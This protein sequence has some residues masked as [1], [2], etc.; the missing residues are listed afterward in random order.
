MKRL[1]A[2]SWEMPPMYGPRATQVSRVLTALPALGWSPT[3]VC[4]DP[5][6]GGPHWFA[7]SAAQNPGVT[8]VRVPSRQESFVVRATWRI[9]PMLRDYPDTARVW[10]R[11]A[12]HAA[13]RVAASESPA[14]L[15]S[16][17]QPWSDHLI[18]LRV[19]RATQLPWVAHFSDPWAD[20]PYA[21]LRQ[22]SIWGRMEAEVIRDATAVVFV[23]QETADL[24]M[25]KY[26]E[27]WR[28]KVAIV[29]H[30][31]VPNQREAAFAQMP[32]GTRPPKLVYTGRFYRGVR[33]PLA[34]F[35][36]LATLNRQSPLAGQLELSL[37]GPDVGD[38]AAEAV[39]LGLGRVVK[40][41]GKVSPSM[42]ADAAAAADALLVID[43]PSDG[44]SVFLPSKLVD[45][46]AFRKPIL[47]LT[48]A[49]GA[50]ASLLNRLHFPVVQPDDV[51]AIAS[52][53][54]ALLRQ[55]RQGT[56]AVDDAFDSVASDYDISNTARLLSDVLARACA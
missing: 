15:I 17:A 20:S 40:L 32:N 37:T 27:A 18:G 45:Y 26:P 53:V 24:V 44:A 56:L 9:A 33:T 54:Q 2:V 55:F 16:F 14:A 51:P 12:T 13:V 35:E 4:M 34:L 21:T 5:R 28:R 49:R 50:T 31:F 43:A 3:V 25:K 47:G 52:A 23:T 41:H 30:G 6:P 46:L 42:A 48:P 10:I 36:A 29:P 38:Y 39:R 8:F 7:N 11:P 1:L 19:H 22:R